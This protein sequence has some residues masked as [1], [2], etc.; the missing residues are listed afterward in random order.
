MKYIDLYR[1]LRFSL[2]ISLTISCDTPSFLP[3]ARR[4]SF[5]SLKSSMISRRLASGSRGRPVCLPCALARSIPSSDPLGDQG[6]VELGERGHDPEQ[7][8]GLRRGG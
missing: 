6:A 8:P 7:Q 3:I 5:P 4:E 2:P 1:S